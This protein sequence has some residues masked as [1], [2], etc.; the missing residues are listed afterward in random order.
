VAVTHRLA[1]ALEDLEGQEQR[2]HPSDQPRGPP[3]PSRQ[4][5]GFEE[6]DDSVDEERRSDDLHV[7][8]QKSIT[9]S[10]MAP[11]TDTAARASL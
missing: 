6:D 8:R 5:P 4:R 10:A 9:T 3:P 2:R 7:L 11:S 1:F